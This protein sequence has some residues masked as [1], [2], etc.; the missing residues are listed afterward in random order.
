VAYKQ[1]R[2]DKRAAE[3]RP[4]RWVGTATEL[5]AYCHISTNK[6]N[7]TII[8]SQN[9]AATRS[10]TEYHNNT[11]RINQNTKIQK[12]K[13]K[14]TKTPKSDGPAIDQLTTTTLPPLC[15]CRRT[16]SGIITHDIECIQY[17]HQTGQK[18]A[19]RTKQ[20]RT[21]RSRNQSHHEDTDDDEADEEEAEDEEEPTA[22]TPQP[23]RTKINPSDLRK[24]KHTDDIT[25]P[26]H[27]KRHK[28]LIIDS[29]DEED[30]ANEGGKH[31]ES[32]HHSHKG[33]T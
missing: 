24:R 11:A 3:G 1:A 27:F 10:K 4:P 22:T 20:R 13:S 18:A 31:E 7:Q 26:A 16:S 33:V 30:T 9:T 23:K 17:K 15:K 6:R 29:S 14:K 8:L 12:K 2:D 19:G 21:K 28:R 25:R 32:P 5:A